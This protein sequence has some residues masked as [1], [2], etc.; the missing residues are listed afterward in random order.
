M[1]RHSNIDSIVREEIGRQLTA[2]HSVKIHLAESRLRAIV[3]AQIMKSEDEDK[4]KKSNEYF[5][6]FTK[7]L[8]ELEEKFN[9]KLQSLNPPENKNFILY[10]YPELASFF[11]N[12]AVLC[13]KFRIAVAALQYVTEEEM[14]DI[15]KK[16]KEKG[17]PN[18]LQRKMNAMDYG[19]KNLSLDFSSGGRLANSAMGLIPNLFSS[20]LLNGEGK[21]GKSRST[22]TSKVYGNTKTMYDE[23]DLTQILIFITKKFPKQ[24]GNVY[25]DYTTA[26]Q[27]V[28]KYRQELSL[29]MSCC[30]K[31]IEMANEAIESPIFDDMIRKT[32]GEIDTNK[33]TSAT[34]QQQTAQPQQQSSQYSV[35]NASSNVGNNNYQNNFTHS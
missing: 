24:R 18:F 34:T 23:M 21:L 10:N 11:A 35:P 26:L 14:K 7:R 27:T 32:K 9:P 29:E 8:L 31:L 22:Y 3:E 20:A 28:K 1:H 33:G 15:E 5:E 13:Y 30:D 2:D 4:N 19:Y 6:E 17:G 16:R 25:Q 12:G